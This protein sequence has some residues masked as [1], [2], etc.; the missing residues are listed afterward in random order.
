MISG[1]VKTSMCSVGRG[2]ANAGTRGR[3][4]VDAGYRRAQEL[5]TV[6]RVGTCVGHFLRLGPEKQQF[7]CTIG[8]AKSKHFMRP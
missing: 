3:R 6:H 7:F 5:A 1:M 8:R 2:A 4:A